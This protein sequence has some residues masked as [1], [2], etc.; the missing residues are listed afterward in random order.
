M[1]SRKRPRRAAP[2]RIVHI[3]AELSPYA[4][5]GGLGEA[6]AVLAQFQARA[7][8]EATIIVPFYREIVDRRLDVELVG[9]SQ[10]VVIAGRRDEV[11]VYRLKTD[12]TSPEPRIYFLANQHFFDRD[13]IYGDARGEFGDNARR[14]AFFCVAALQVLPSLVDAPAVI[15]AHDW[16]AAL[17]PVYLRSWMAGHPYYDQLASVLSVH[18]AGFQGHFP[19]QTMSD[20]G[21]PWDWYTMHR[22]EWHGRVNFL[23]GGMVA[24]DAVSTV[25]RTHADELRTPGGG[26]GLDGAFRELG[27]RFVGITNGIDETIWNPTTDPHIAATYSAEDLGGK[28]ADKAALQ[29]HFGLPVSPRTPVFAMA[30][31]MVYQ[32][33]IDL[34]I[35]SGLTALDAQFVF[36]G[37]GEPRYVHALQQL[38]RR[39]PERVALDTKFSDVLEHRVLAGADVLLMPSLYEPCGLTQ[40]RAQRYGTLPLARRVGGLADTIDDGRSGFLFDDYT[41]HDFAEGVIR[42]LRTYSDPSAW[43][44]MQRTAMAKSFSWSHAEQGYE[45]LYRSALERR[46][47]SGGPTA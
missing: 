4:R 33:G 32:K 11:R 7:G 38:A 41:V 21:I 5:T 37:H 8:H 34:I 22:M 1:S 26:F 2:L 47:T 46:A 30:A 19:T 25:S 6:V 35:D 14:F 27:D 13:G 40:M 3:A 12:G 9:D 20:L 45:R 44:A 29:G 16:H 23:K 28:A 36:L 24:A 10:Q 17:A 18:N 39:A 42:T 31:R 43:T 15:H